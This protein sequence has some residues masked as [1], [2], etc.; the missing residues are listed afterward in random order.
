[1]RVTGIGL[2]LASGAALAVA[3]EIKK[4]E[5]TPD[6]ASH[7][8]AAPARCSLD[9]L[10]LPDNTVV[11]ATGAYAG[12]ETNYQIDQSGH[13]ATRFDV[14]VHSPDKPVVLMLSAYE[15]S[16]WQV[17][18]TAGTRIL[19]AVVTGYYRQGVAGLPTSTPLLNSSY[20]NK[21]PCGSFYLSDT[22]LGE[23]NP[24]ARRAL[25]RPVTMVYPASQGK[26]V[27]GAPLPAKAEVLTDTDVSLDAFRDP[28]APLAGKPGLDAAVRKGILRKATLQDAQAWADALAQKG[29][30]P[31]LPPVAGGKVKARLP[32]AFY[33]GYV[34]L[35]PFV[36]PAGLYGAHS[37]S[38]YVPKGIPTPTGNLG[39]ST[40]YNYNDLSCTGSDCPR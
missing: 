21:G 37:T 5:F 13:A 31:D 12:R 35:K 1:M 14:V 16:V 9:N 24:L 8:L 4:M 17:G 33:G 6:L 22:T 29:P 19:A 18:W 27:M 11:Y 25:G 26:A 2:L 10:D 39:H 20:A 30:A 40:V 7:G 36:V 23:L 3:G 32:L 34:V 15:P 38:F 28:E